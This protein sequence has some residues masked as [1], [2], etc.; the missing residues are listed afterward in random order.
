MVEKEIGSES[1]IKRN[2]SFILFFGIL[3]FAFSI[4]AI[5]FLTGISG[6]VIGEVRS[7]YANFIGFLLLFALIVIIEITLIYKRNKNKDS[8]TDI[9]DILRQN[10]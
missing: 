7:S 1:R 2:N 8:N 3:T 4:F 6:N 5:Y 9:R 10:S